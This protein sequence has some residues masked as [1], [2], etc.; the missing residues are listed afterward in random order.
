MARPIAEQRFAV[1]DVETSGLRPGRHRLLQVGV[2]LVDGSGAV[3]HR[4]SSLIAPKRRW[5]FRVGPSRIHGIRRRDL[6]SAPPL[7][8]VLR[9]LA[10]MLQDA[11]LVAHN[12][13]FD[14]QFLQRAAE[15][16]GVT[17]ALQQ[18]LCTLRMS[19]R[20]D[21]DRNMRHRLG[22][23]CVRYDVTL[24]QPHHA[25]SDAAATAEV[26]PH[27]L[28]AHQVDTDDELRSLLIALQNP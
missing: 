26:L 20:L 12:A 23:L 22:D 15:S 19:R 28:R 21:P 11:Q 16:A 4:W 27:L 6:R 14:V 9:E 18:P 2:V 1:V 10:P 24:A 13:S 17:L 8:D 25:L 7:A 5:F 3:L